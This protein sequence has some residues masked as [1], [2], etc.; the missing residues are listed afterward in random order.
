MMPCPTEQPAR[1]SEQFR[2]AMA[3]A[4]AALLTEVRYVEQTV[5][6][7]KKIVLAGFAVAEDVDPEGRILV[8]QKGCNFMEMVE[9]VEKEQDCVGRVRFIVYPNNDNW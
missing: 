1:Y 9:V 2:E 8:L 3:M 7:V 5:L 4:F 6:P